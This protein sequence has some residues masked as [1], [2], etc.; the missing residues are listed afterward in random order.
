M[1]TFINKAKCNLQP[2]YFPLSQSSCK[3]AVLTSTVHCHTVGQ[4]LFALS[5]LKYCNSTGTSPRGLPYS[6]VCFADKKNTWIPKSQRSQSNKVQ[7]DGQCD[8]VEH[9][10]AGTRYILIITEWC[11]L[12]D[13]VKIFQTWAPLS[14]SL[15]HLSRPINSQASPSLILIPF[16]CFTWQETGESHRH[17]RIQPN[18]P[19][20][21]Q[22]RIIFGPSVEVCLINPFL[23]PPA[24]RLMHSV[25]DTLGRFAYPSTPSDLKGICKY[26]LFLTGHVFRLINTTLSVDKSSVFISVKEN[27]KHSAF[28]GANFR[29]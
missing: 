25:T 19:A 7:S 18:T 5:T 22:I 12:K 17:S 2:P 1:K 8:A 16:L 24:P 4:N 28:L 26:L 10:S 13:W 27:E 9:L 29:H 6:V 20:D 11:Q 15:L 3:P 23:V 14:L 21:P